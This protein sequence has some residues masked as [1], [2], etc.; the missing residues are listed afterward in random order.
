VVVVHSAGLIQQFVIIDFISQGREEK[1]E[2][3][4]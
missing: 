3:K 4:T 1:K 2:E